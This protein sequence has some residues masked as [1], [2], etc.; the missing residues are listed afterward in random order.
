MDKSGGQ[1]PNSSRQ[2]SQTWRGVGKGTLMESHALLL[3]I[4]VESEPALM[5]FL[6]QGGGRKSSSGSLVSKAQHR[7]IESQFTG[8]TN[9]ERWQA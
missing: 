6:R 4:E 2:A 8:R 7:R 3:P 9:L 1:P 5:R